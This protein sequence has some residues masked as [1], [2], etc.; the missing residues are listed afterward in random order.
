MMEWI[1]DWLFLPHS[2]YDL[3]IVSLYATGTALVILLV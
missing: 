1:N 2:L 3:L